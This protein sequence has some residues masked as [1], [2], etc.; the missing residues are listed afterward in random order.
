MTGMCPRMNGVPASLGD[1]DTERQRDIERH[2]DIERD[3][4]RYIERASET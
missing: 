3:T 4:E 2:R 1:G